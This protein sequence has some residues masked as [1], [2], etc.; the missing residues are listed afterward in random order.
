MSFCY[1]RCCLVV[2]KRYEGV[3]NREVEVD[4]KVEDPY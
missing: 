1:C 4:P 2:A 3:W